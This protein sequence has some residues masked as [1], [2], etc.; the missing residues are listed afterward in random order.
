MIYLILYVYVLYSVFVFGFLA[1]EKI[2]IILLMIYLRSI[3]IYVKIDDEL[4]SRLSTISKD[5]HFCI[6]SLFF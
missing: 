4:V 2:E 5:S 6:L 3:T 1:V